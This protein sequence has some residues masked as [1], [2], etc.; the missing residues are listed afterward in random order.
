M[1]I[2]NGKNQDIIEIMNVIK[3]A[4]KDMEARGIYQWDDIYPSE[5]IILNDINKN[6]LYVATNETGMIQG[7]IVLNEHQDTAYKAIEWKYNSGRQ[8]I[9]HRLCIHPNHQG[10]G[11]ARML[12][13][14]AEDLGSQKKYEAIRLD[15]FI[16]NIRAGRMYEQVGYEK[17]GIVTF[18]KGDFYC[19]EKG[20]SN[21]Y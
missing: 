8:L 16:P 21:N 9:I 7:I 3:E 6:N 11:I 4:V 18:R 2:R 17:R 14:F 1:T 13:K 5:E 20:L 10:K 15:A 19:Y 12:I